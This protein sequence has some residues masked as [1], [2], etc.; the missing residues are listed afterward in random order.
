M[1]F[2]ELYSECKTQVRET[3]N[4]WWVNENMTPTE[5]DIIITIIENFINKVN[6]ENTIVQSMYPWESTKGSAATVATNLVAPLW[7]E[8]FTPF[9]HQA[10]AWHELLNNKKSIIVTTGTGSGKTECFLVPI[11]KDLGDRAKRNQRLQDDFHPVEALFLYPLNALMND[12]KERIDKFLYNLDGHGANVSFAIY[13]GNTP[14]NQAAGEEYEVAKNVAEAV[15]IKTCKN[16]KWSTDAPVLHERITREEIRRNGSSILITNPSMLEYMLLRKKDNEIFEKS[17]GQLKWIVID[18]THTFTGAAAAELAYLLRR[19]MLAFD[20]DPKNVRFV[21]SSAT[22]SGPT[23][24]AKLKDFVADLSNQDVNQIEIIS[25][26]RQ[27]HRN[28]A[29]GNKSEDDKVEEIENRLYQTGAD[30][31]L[32]LN[33]LIPNRLGIGSTVEEKLE[34]LDKLTDDK[35]RAKVHFFFPALDKGATYTFNGMSEEFPLFVCEECGHLVIGAELNSQG[36]I[37][38]LDSS[39]EPRDIFDEE[40]TN[41]YDDDTKDSN[42]TESESRERLIGIIDHN[43]ATAHQ[44]A[45]AVSIINGKLVADPSGR[46]SYTSGHTCPCCG[47]DNSKSRAKKLEGGSTDYNIKDFLKALTCPPAFISR[48]IAPSLLSQMIENGNNCPHKGQQYISFVDSRQGCSRATLSQNVEIER[49]WIYSRIFEMLSELAPS[50]LTEY[51]NRK[52][53]ALQRL[54]QGDTTAL[55]ELTFFCNLINSLSQSKDC[56]SWQ[57]IA[58]RLMQDPDFNLLFDIYDTSKQHLSGGTQVNRALGTAISTDDWKKRR[59]VHSIMF[60]A[61]SNRPKNANAP[62]T[63][64]LFRTH[65]PKLDRL[66]RPSSLLSIIG[67]DEEWRDIIKTYLDFSVR[68]NGSFFLKPKDTTSCNKDAYIDIFDL[69]RYKYTSE[70]RRP[71][72]KPSEQTGIYQLVKQAY[73]DTYAQLIIDEMWD[74]LTQGSDPILTRGEKLKVYKNNGVPYRQDWVSFNSTQGYYINLYDISFKLYDKIYICPE[75]KRPLDVC[76]KEYTWYQTKGVGYQKVTGPFYWSAIPYSLNRTYADVEQ[77]HKL[78]RAEI[79]HLWNKRLYKY[80]SRPM[81]FVQK[82][83][84]AQLNTQEA[85]QYLIDFKDDHKINILACSTTMEM[86]VD[87]GS[88]ELVMMNNVPPQASNYKQRAGRSGRMEQNRSASIALCGQDIHSSSVCA[89]PLLLINRH[90][91][92]PY[93]DFDSEIILQRQ[94]NAYVFKS[95]FN[96][97]SLGENGTTVMDFFTDY[98]Y[99][100]YADHAGKERVDYSVIRNGVTKQILNLAN[101]TPVTNS[102]YHNFI[103]NLNDYCQYGICP[104]DK[105]ISD[106]LDNLYKLSKK[107]NPRDIKKYVQNVIEAAQKLHDEFER[108]V[109]HLEEYFNEGAKAK[110]FTLS[111]I[112]DLKQNSTKFKWQIKEEPQFSRYM[113]GMHFKWTSFLKT[114]LLEYMSTHQFTPNA[115]M[116]LDIIE[117]IVSKQDA[118]N[119][120]RKGANKQPSTDLVRGLSQFAPGKIVAINNSVY[121]VG[122]VDWSKPFDYYTIDNGYLSIS[123]GQVGQV[124]IYPDAFRADYGVSRDTSTDVYSRVYAQFLEMNDTGIT[125]DPCI[126]ANQG[127]SPLSLR[128]SDKWQGQTPYILYYN[129]GQGEGYSVCVK[130][131]RAVI[132]KDSYQLGHKDPK[133]HTQWICRHLPLRREPEDDNSTSTPVSGN[134]NCTEGDIKHGV[135]FAGKLQTH[136]CEMLLSKPNNH[137]I[138]EFDVNSVED[139]NILTTFAIVLCNAFAEDIQRERS[140]IDFFISRRGTLCI[141]DTAKG[142]AGISNQLTAGKIKD[143]I[144]NAIYTKML[145][146]TD[147]SHI[148]DRNTVRYYNSIDIDGFKDWLEWAK[149]IVEDEVPQAIKN[150]YGTAVS[151]ESINTLVDAI[152][153]DKKSYIFFNDEVKAYNY[154]DATI[155]YDSN[156]DRHIY[157]ENGWSVLK[158]FYKMHTLDHR[159]ILFV[160][161]MQIIVPAIR[162]MLLNLDDSRNRLHSCTIGN[163][164]YQPLALA[165]GKLYFTDARR[166]NCLNQHWGTVV[167][168]IPYDPKSISIVKGAPLDPN[169]LCTGTKI[170]H[171]EKDVQINADDLLARIIHEETMEHNHSMIQQFIDTSANKT[172]SFK[173]TDEHL[174]SHLGILLLIKVLKT[175]VKKIQNPKIGTI[176]YYGEKYTDYSDKWAF[177]PNHDPWCSFKNF[178]YS[179]QRDDELKKYCTTSSIPIDIKIEK[180]PHWRVLEISNGT[181]VLRIYPD[182][183]FTNGWRSDN[184]PKSKNAEDTDIEIKTVQK[185][186]FDIDLK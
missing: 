160:G 75:T 185:I 41:D 3:L 182:G 150:D 26:K 63:L 87:V 152:N 27:L 166:W 36:K 67:S 143:L 179:S 15:S 7:K 111:D 94:I 98:I 81:V 105:R 78:N 163:F 82:E 129:S 137:L 109:Q 138:Q 146:V 99:G 128:T 141:F 33:E 38:P 127:H 43:C 16:A 132:E 116:P 21:T 145:R 169:A 61:L 134:C 44:N 144:K 164:K 167:F 92:A 100:S 72:N 5:K 135:I 88:L 1:K 59:Y 113:R 136:F 76:I 172:I 119:Q 56:L 28:K 96:H 104:Q 130:C 51:E 47:K 53:N 79:Q 91:S 103:A 101:R 29:T 183:G 124:V 24:A 106:S 73:T 122:G 20:V 23:G 93:V 50:R 125:F 80:Y 140:E 126:L 161:N 157:N 84:T 159:E 86:G 13:N 120:Y 34:Y 54:Q 65:Y 32:S 17:R 6:G 165:N 154:Y 186:K 35:M 10:K 118:S 158:D 123:P 184:L 139:M 147:P 71:R 181:H 151:K 175:I 58:D 9:V 90:I 42:T 11:I 168:S 148:L 85:R 45:V 102:A 77:W 149:A 68:N 162:D 95:V 114:N 83:H 97:I 2:S 156:G 142:G 57:E 40:E 117:L 153:S 173:Y 14:E 121:K 55:A 22:I 177:D 18:E 48:I 178:K 39:I 115:N 8:Q 89:S 171:I 37:I 108:T 107:I 64:G 60:Y 69:S 155:V 31:Y 49:E 131:G 25:G 110:N 180:L 30:N 66:T 52:D 74:A 170:I 12:Q 133:D 112:N 176:E 62:E 46:Y 174:K 19:V 4:S 70:T